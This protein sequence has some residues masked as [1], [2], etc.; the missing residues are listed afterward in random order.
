[1]EVRM[2]TQ[3][4]PTLI[5]M[6]AGMG[7]RFGGLKQ[8]TPV[9]PSGEMIIDY[10]IYDAI[11]AGFEK[12]VFVIKH[13]IEDTFKQH[14]GDRIARQIPVEYVYQEL[15]NLPDGY[16]VPEGRVKPWGTGHAVLSC[17]G[18]V[19]GPFMV[20]NA[21]DYY[22][23]ECFKLLYDFMVTE[24]SSDKLH[25]A[26]AG[27]V[28]ENTLTENGYVSRGICSVDDGGYLTGL[29]ERTHIEIRGDQSMF[30][31]DDGKTWEVLP[32]GCAVSMNCWAFPAEALPR[33]EDKFRNFLDDSHTNPLKSEFYLPFAVDAMVANGEADVQ[34]LHTRDKWYGMTYAEDH[35]KVIDALQTLI[36]NGA[37]PERLWTK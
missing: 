11:A 10:S 34:V 12:I 21:D 3:K 7:S 15:D 31:E 28:L 1:M 13:E 32:V 18:T 4:K 14:I 37:Y 25:I 5:I 20:I 26:M 23:R 27:Y 33:F 17:L 29:V 36:N 22:G 2:N 24:T 16:T 9:G 19:D 30:T 8:I 35:Q 6:A